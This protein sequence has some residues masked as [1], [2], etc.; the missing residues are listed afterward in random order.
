MSNGYYAEPAPTYFDGKRVVVA[1]QEYPSDKNGH[2]GQVKLLDA[3]G[4]D[5]GCTKGEDNIVELD[6]W[7]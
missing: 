3:D 4:L 1:G 6:S 2:S 7:E 5:D